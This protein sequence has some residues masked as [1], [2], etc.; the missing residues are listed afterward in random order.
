MRITA[1]SLL[2]IENGVLTF[3]TYLFLPDDRVRFFEMN[4]IQLFGYKSFSINI[5]FYL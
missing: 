3:F 4:T 1:I 5:C 2:L